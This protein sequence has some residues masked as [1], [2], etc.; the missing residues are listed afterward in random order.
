MSSL[1]IESVHFFPVPRHVA[2]P[3]IGLDAGG[4][5]VGA[6]ADMGAHVSC[7]VAGLREGLTAS[8]AGVGAVAGM[9]AFVLHQAARLREGHARGGAGYLCSLTNGFFFPSWY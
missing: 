1:L 3:R 8:G 7:Q 2:G 4:T 6:V 9:G 5:G